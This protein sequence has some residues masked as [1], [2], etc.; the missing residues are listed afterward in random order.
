MNP[1]ERMHLTPPARSA[2]PLPLVRYDPA[3]AAFQEYHEPHQVALRRLR[4]TMANRYGWRLPV[5]AQTEMPI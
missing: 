5:L 1:Y 3:F 4:R 2:R